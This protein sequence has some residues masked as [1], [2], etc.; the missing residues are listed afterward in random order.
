MSPT[1]NGSSV[2]EHFERGNAI[3]IR[4]RIMFNIYLPQQSTN[5]T[6]RRLRT[7]EVQIRH[8]CFCVVYCPAGTD[9]N[10]ATLSMVSSYQVSTPNKKMLVLHKQTFPGICVLL[11]PQVLFWKPQSLPKGF[12][13]DSSRLLS[14]KH[15]KHITKLS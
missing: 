11:L 14:P 5:I 9:V 3:E 7:T 1:L 2:L 6:I 13:L 15:D 12:S 10:T 4:N 8:K